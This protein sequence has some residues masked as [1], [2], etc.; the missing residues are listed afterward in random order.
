M[1][2]EAL[3]LDLVFKLVHILRQEMQH[4]SSEHFQGR[5]LYALSAL[6]RGN[7]Q[8]LKTFHATNGL[9]ILHQLAVKSNERI[10]RKLIIFV[11]D[12]V[13]PDMIE[14]LVLPS[15]GHLQL[16]CLAFTA[17][18]RDARVQQEALEGLRILSQIKAC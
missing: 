13:N 12:A 6:I 15:R 3:G 16:W 7:E 9:A 5:V 14:H 11:S 1:Q 17:Y 8:A 4:T 2:R 18:A 10:L